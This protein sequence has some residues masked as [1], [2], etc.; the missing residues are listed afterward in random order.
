MKKMVVLIFKNLP[1]G[2]KFKMLYLRRR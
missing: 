2:Q 1:S